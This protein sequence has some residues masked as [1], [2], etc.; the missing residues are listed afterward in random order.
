MRRI[1]HAT[2]LI[3]IVLLSA[4]ALTGCSSAQAFGELLATPT[5]PPVV[6]VTGLDAQPTATAVPPTPTTAPS[7]TATAVPPTITPTPVAPAQAPRATAAPVVP[8]GVYVTALRVDPAVAQSDAT[9]MFTVT[10]LNTTGQARTYTWYVKIYSPDQPNSFGETTKIP[11]TIPPGVSQL[12]AIPN[13][14]T[15]TFFGC[16]PFTAR[17]F[18]WDTSGQIDPFVQ[19]YEFRKPDGTILATPF[20]VCP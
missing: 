2:W 7:P 17:A 13:W 1:A 16:L 3:T 9:P 10:F 8:P 12:Q 18:F 14:K 19:A 15:R 4:L 5:L 6:P 20:S 11:H